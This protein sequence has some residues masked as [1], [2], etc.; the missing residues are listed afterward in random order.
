[1]SATTT[2]Y[3][4][5]LAT[6]V[7]VWLA[8]PDPVRYGAAQLALLDAAEQDRYRRLR[9]PDDRRLFLAAHVLVR[10]TLSLYAAVEPAAWRF[11]SR[12]HGRPEIAVPALPVNLRFN[13]SHTAGLAACVVSVDEA[14]GVDVERIAARG[15]LPGIAARV[16]APPERRDLE[17]RE[18][19]TDYVDRF[20]TYWTLREAWS[21][22]LGTGLAHADRS[23]WFD[24]DGVCTL[25]A[26]GK[27]IPSGSDWQC[28]VLRPTG[29]HCLAVV[30]DVGDAGRRPVRCRFLVP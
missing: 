26:G 28:A 22:A 3:L 30:Q 20:Y 1:V 23:A 21:K 25:H 13:L 19:G 7:H 17:A 9:F 4:D 29:D 18:G 27:G 24:P 5:A 11:A 2:S 14:C 6:E 16:F 12:A 15:N 8:R 10:R